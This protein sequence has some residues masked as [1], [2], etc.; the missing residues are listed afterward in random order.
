MLTEIK[1]VTL[2]VRLILSIVLH[3]F[4]INLIL[5]RIKSVASGGCS[6]Y[7]GGMEPYD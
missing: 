4:D 6:S 7:T 1:T 3:G 5:E 2:E